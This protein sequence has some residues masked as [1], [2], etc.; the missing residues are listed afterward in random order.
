MDSKLLFGIVWFVGVWASNV[1]A[2]ISSS[3]DF[4]E[5]SCERSLLNIY[6]SSEHVVDKHVTFSAI[7]Q[8]GQ[9]IEITTA[10]AAQ[11][12]YTL[13][14]DFW[15][16]INFRASLLSCYTEISDNS[17]F[18]ATIRIDIA[19][20]TD[21][22][23]ALSYTRTATCPYVWDARE[24][25]C[26]ANYMEVSVRRKIPQIAE[27]GFPEEPADW[28]AAFPDAVSGLMSIWQVVF[29]LTSSRKAMLVKNAN[30]MGYGINTT[31]ARI[32]LRAPYNATEIQYQ[33]VQGTE[34]STVRATIFYKQQWLILMVDTA[35]AC[36]VDDVTFTKDTIVWNVPKNVPILL[37]GASRIKS[38]TIQFGVN[39]VTLSNSEV[40][41]RGYTVIDSDQSTR[42]LVPMGAL[43]GY[44]KSHVRREEIGITY[45]IA[46]F[47]EN[48][49][50]DSRWGI[51]KHTI[52]KE[53]TSPFIP[54]PPTI[55]NE[56][57][58]P[59]RV[60]NVTI[61][62]FLPDVVLVNV[63]VGQVT[64]TVDECKK[65]GY[66]ISSII[67]TNG[68]ITFVLKVP[69]TDPD[70][71]IKFVSGENRSYT[72]NVTF[73][74]IVVPSKESYKSSGVIICI[75]PDA[76]PPRIIGSCDAIYLNLI[77]VRGNVDANWRPY[78]NN[79]PLTT[80][81]A[82]KNGYIFKENSTNI[83]ISVP[84]FSSSVMLDDVGSA[85]ISLRLPLSLKD[86]STGLP[87][88][89]VSVSCSYPDKL[90]ECFPNGTITVL[91]LKIAA[92]TN[93]DVS[94]LVLR[95]RSCKPNEVT[96]QAAKFIF[97]ANR[98]GT[99]RMFYN[100]TM[101]YD[102]EVLYFGSGGTSP[103]Y[104][105]QFTCDYSTNGTVIVQYGFD[106]NPTLAGMT[107]YGSLALVMSLS[108]DNSYNIFYKD[109]EYPVVKFLREPLYFEVALLQSIDPRLELF[110][111][112]CWATTSPDRN[113]FP[114]WDIVDN[115]CEF[116]ESDKTIFHPVTANTRV[117]FPSHLKRFEVKM[118]TFV[119][120][121][122][123]LGE[124]YFHCNV[125]ICNSEQQSSDPL[126]TKSCIP[127]KQRIGRS[128]HPSN[129]YGY[130]SSGMILLQSNLLY[131]F[132]PY[133]K[134]TPS[135]RSHS[136]TI[137]YF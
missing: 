58:V 102:N 131:F 61:G 33:N 28:A 64:R 37:T 56:T 85:G 12:G 134:I 62:T 42:V 38:Q 2:Q 74:F 71:Q 93:M 104:R 81:Y 80:E 123:Y 50:E 30:D 54:Q 109:M 10:V 96:D 15:G 25:V 35:A 36:P 41:R 43:G 59:S 127:A 90:I 21:N 111:E 77:I 6:V 100:T 45:S 87:M 73:G 4:L 91:A 75:V 120:D 1:Q 105:L 7:D 31:E 110:L 98:C 128:V 108:K 22:S 97:T 69:F 47:L 137:I 121:D 95:D 68:S 135:G 19:P 57:Y 117:M 76:V 133:T 132:A 83:M 34:F 9:A 52:I 107:E 125:V 84:R 79:Q 18:T 67:N 92:V 23:K 126:C 26:E 101:T 65:V 114:Q 89:D 17:N 86:S 115:S 130:V 27:S 122:A 103:T 49:W 78:I 40:L 39:L 136:K 88:K 60:F 51:T 94:K 5:V 3:T 112:D 129:K 124:M 82:A 16:N 20:S 72:L 14:Q 13:S 113:S 118:F 99:R 116:A 53:I 44:Y 66:N 32:L 55:T 8:Y 24:I 48:K 63:T 46:L 70:V 11:C 29:H 119:Q 106:L